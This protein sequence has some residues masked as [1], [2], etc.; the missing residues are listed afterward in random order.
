MVKEVTTEG[1]RILD[2]IAALFNH[3]FTYDTAIIGHD[4][5]EAGNALPDETLTKLRNCDAILFG[6]VGHPK[7]DNDPS[8]ESKTRAGIAEDA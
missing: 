8:I 1:K 5:I 3:Q 6:A 4:A 7:Y 2:K